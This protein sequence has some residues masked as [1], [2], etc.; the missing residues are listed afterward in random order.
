[1]HRAGMSAEERTLRSRLAQTVHQRDF[2]R[3]TLVLRE[4]T[5]GKPGCRCSRGQKH[6]GLYLICSQNGKY[7]Q[8]YV[9][10]HWE[11]RVREWLKEYRTARDL[12]EKL[13]RICRQKISERSK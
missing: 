2:V 6:V 8:V 10:K 7:S 12:L 3:G 13:S 1:M 9:P 4:V 5:C 11:G